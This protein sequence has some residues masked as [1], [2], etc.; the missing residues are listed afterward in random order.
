MIDTS[1]LELDTI[2]SRLEMLEREQPELMSACAYYRRILPML[3]AAQPVVAPF[4][5]ERGRAQRKIEQGI[6]LLR[7][8]RLPF[9]ATV[10]QSLFS[11]VC[12]GIM[13]AA[14]ATPHAIQKIRA[15][16]RESP[17]QLPLVALMDALL[18][19]NSEPL[20][21]TAY[22]LNVDAALLRVIVQNCL[23]PFLYAWAEELGPQVDLAGWD[24]GSCPICGGPA[25][26]AELRGPARA[27]FLRCGQ[28]GADW[29]FGRLQCAHCE[30]MDTRKLGLLHPEGKT[31]R[32]SVQ[33]CAACHAY[34]KM[35]VT[36]EPVRPELL[37]VEDL[38]SM[39]LDL[40]AGKYGY[41]RP[42]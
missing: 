10:T 39:T 35:M 13:G 30:N 1:T 40:I 27:R 18:N 42:R 19:G 38:A 14:Q 4:E 20:E 11:L 8:E 33:T 17:D 34:L 7:E 16:R 26:L 5:L 37:L 25:L 21:R 12:D 24:L 9:S 36:M 28:C 31:E 29:P 22:E 15:V 3:K 2:Q 32:W 23:K 41:L 6:P